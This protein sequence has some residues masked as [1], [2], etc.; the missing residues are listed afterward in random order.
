MGRSRNGVSLKYHCT[1]VWKLLDQNGAVVWRCEK[2]NI[3][4]TDGGKGILDT[5]FRNTDTPYFPVTDFYI[6]LYRGSV[7]KATTLA[8]IPG[9]PSGNGYARILCE[10]STVGFPTIELGDEGDWLVVSKE[11][12][13]EASGGN[14][15]PVDGGFLCTSSNNSGTLIGVVAVPVQRTILAGMQMVV[16]LKIKIS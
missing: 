11:M 9:E 16:Q 3:L 14:I 6:G 10:R 15:G 12:T 13:F 1:W 7:S 5:F 4:A 2:D 8:T